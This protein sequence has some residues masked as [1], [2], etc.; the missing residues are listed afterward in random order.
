MIFSVS[1]P[2]QILR[3]LNS[4]DY[5]FFHDPISLSLGSYVVP[6]VCSLRTRQAGNPFLCY[7]YVRILQVLGH[8]HLF[9]W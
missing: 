2:F 4:H 8:L 3:N 1:Y 9:V 5:Y 7:F 6:F